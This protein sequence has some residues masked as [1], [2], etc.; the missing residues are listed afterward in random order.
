M[1]KV[2]YHP[3]EFN[4]RVEGHAG[5]GKPGED[6]VC[7]GISTL[8]FTL[9]AAADEFN[10]HLYLNEA[11]GVMDVRCYPSEETEERCRTVFDTLALGYELLAAKYPDNIIMGGRHD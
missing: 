1:T 5:A 3:D 7:A 11:D 10:M 4:L 2:T 6:I 9:V 8:G